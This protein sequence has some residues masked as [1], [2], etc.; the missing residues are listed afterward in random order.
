MRIIFDRSKLCGWS[1]IGLSAK[2][3]RAGEMRCTYSEGFSC[4]LLDKSESHKT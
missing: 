1:A 2:G 4:L 3:E